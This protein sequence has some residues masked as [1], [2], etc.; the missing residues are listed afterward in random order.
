MG[1]SL[2]KSVTVLLPAF[3]EEEA[4]GETVRHIIQLYPDFEVLVIDDGS[5]DGTRQ[6]AIDSGASVFSHPYNIGNGAALKSGLRRARGKWTLMMDGDGQHRPEDIDKLLSHKENFD[7]VV[8][9]RSKKSKTSTH[10]N[11]ANYM[12]N[13][14]ASYVTSFPVQDLTSGFRLV[15]TEIAQR[16]IYLLPN[17]FSSPTTITMAYLHSGLSVKYVAIQTLARQGKSKIRLAKDGPRFF[18]I[19]LKIATLFSPLRIF[20]PLSVLLFFL[21]LLLYLYTFITVHRFTNMSALL[22]SSGLLVFVL[23]LVSEQ[24]SQVHSSKLE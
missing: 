20:V 12:Y 2:E 9:A 18:L 15:R 16:Y 17:T 13:R 6:A 7:M 10:R 5:T 21:G 1:Q 11:I 22:F 24:I 4:I 8:G 23:G 19:I 14:L 3:N